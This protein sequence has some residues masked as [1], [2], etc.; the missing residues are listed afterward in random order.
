MTKSSTENDSPPEYSTVAN[1][2]QGQT[3]ISI[4]KEP[5]R[6]ENDFSGAVLP[7]NNQQERKCCSREKVCTGIWFII[8]MAA[9]SLRNIFHG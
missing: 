4:T 5:S 1:I 9:F 2:P 8:A 7:E 3:A 6:P